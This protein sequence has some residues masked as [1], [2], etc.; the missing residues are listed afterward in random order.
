V[1]QSKRA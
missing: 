1:A